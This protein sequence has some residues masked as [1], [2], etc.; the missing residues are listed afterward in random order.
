MVI[1][2]VIIVSIAIY[3]LFSFLM[4]AVC[5]SCRRGHYK[6]LKARCLMSGE[7]VRYYT[8]AI[9]SLV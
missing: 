6:S 9:H 7:Q 4:I 5:S 1:V 3:L 2:M 8:L